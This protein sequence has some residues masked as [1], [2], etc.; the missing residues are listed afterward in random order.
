MW[1]KKSEDSPC[2][3]SVGE[4]RPPVTDDGVADRPDPLL[5]ANEGHVQVMVAAACHSQMTLALVNY[6]YVY[7]DD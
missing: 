3:L 1:L 4:P 2:D 6:N 7:M 5:R